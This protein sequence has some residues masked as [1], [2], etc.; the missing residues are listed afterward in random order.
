M[1]THSLRLDDK[2]FETH[3]EVQKMPAHWLMA[4]LGKRVLRP[5]GRE[6]TRWLLDNA[7]IDP[8]D[9]VIEL[10]PGL[11]VTASEILQRG[12]RS[13]AAIER[14]VEALRLTR[15]ALSRSGYAEPRVLQGDAAN[16]PLPDRSASLVFGEAMLSMHSH[17]KKQLIMKEARRLL[18]PGGRYVIHELCVVPNDIDEA[19][20]ASIQRD[21][22]ATI[23]VGV[24]IGTPSEWLNWLAEA[25]FGV[26]RM[27]LAPMRLL[28]VDR[29]LDDE[30]IVGASRFVFNTLRTAGALKR[31]AAVRASFRRHQ[32][33]LRAVAIVARVQP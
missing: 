8:S 25:K 30:G 33:H 9:D 13:Y 32:D 23:H 21:L 14:N 2:P 1:T 24:R 11:G 27:T 4:Y 31:L 17:A 6:T 7:H 15:T 29:L 28:E 18:R 3:L 5:G 26:Q 20:M 12:P 10:A 16:V 19:S 22:S